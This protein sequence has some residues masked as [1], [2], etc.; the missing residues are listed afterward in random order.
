MTTTNSLVSHTEKVLGG[1]KPAKRLAAIRHT[2]FD[3]ERATTAKNAKSALSDYLSECVGEQISS[4]TKRLRINLASAAAGSVLAGLGVKDGWN[5][6]AAEACSDVDNEELQ[7]LEDTVAGGLWDGAEHPWRREYKANQS[8]H[9]DDLPNHSGSFHFEVLRALDKAKLGDEDALYASDVLSHMSLLSAKDLTSKPEI[10]KVKAQM[11]AAG[12]SVEKWEVAIS[13]Y[14]M[15]NLRGLIVYEDLM[16]GGKPNPKSRKN[17]QQFLTASHSKV[18]FDDFN[19][20]VFLERDGRSVSLDDETLRE[21]MFLMR[22]AGLPIDKEPAS[23]ALSNLALRDRRHPVRDYLRGLKWDGKKRVDTWL[24][25]Y[26]GAKCTELNSALGRKFLV[27]AVRRIMQPGV[28]LRAMPIL[29]GEQNI[30]KSLVFK[31]LAVR[32]DWYT[33]SLE[34]G[35]DPKEVI[36]LTEGKWIVETPELSGM[37][38]RDVEHVKAMIS[39]DVDKAR[40]AYGRFSTEVPRQFV[41]GGTTNTDEYLKDRTGNTRFWGIKVKKPDIEALEHDRDQL[42][43]EA[44]VLEAN[45]EAHWLDTLELQDLAKAS[46]QKREE[47][48]PLEEKWIALF[49]Q[50]KKAGDIF[51]QSDDMYRATGLEDVTKLHQGHKKSLRYAAQRTGW[52]SARKRTSKDQRPWGYVPTGVKPEIA[53]VAVYDRINQRF[54]APAK[55]RQTRGGL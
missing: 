24:A 43:A 9:R 18:W 48:T 12:L 16:N 26:A 50:A 8:R 32:P 13:N 35:C 22:E 10:V 53:S 37:S 4:T 34:L 28:K 14:R 47:Q 51:I 45:G 30:G 27:G 44:V 41:L 15:A 7:D 19:K 36:E 40:L 54:K 33:D 23:D 38:N 31:T 25:K 29:E 20:K 3:L 11:K 42:W 49:Q 52:V 46:A 55:S 5:V 2:L 17:V 21:W 6:I 1:R 39:R